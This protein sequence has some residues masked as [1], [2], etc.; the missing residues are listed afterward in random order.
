MGHGSM[1]FDGERFFWLQQPD[2]Y[3]ERCAQPLGGD[4]LTGHVPKRYI[5]EPKPQ[6]LEHQQCDDYAIHVPGGYRL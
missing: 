1:D 4:Q 2:D 5:S 3:G 6:Q